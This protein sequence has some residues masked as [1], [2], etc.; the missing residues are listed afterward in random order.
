[1]IYYL[2]HTIITFALAYLFTI[3]PK[4]AGV[5][6]FQVK[7]LNIFQIITILNIILA[8]YLVASKTGIA[9]FNLLILIHLLADSFPLSSE[10]K[11]IVQ[12]AKIFNIISHILVGIFILVINPNLFGLF[13]I[14]II[15]ISI[16]A[17]D[18]NIEKDLFIK[19]K[20]GK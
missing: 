12:E 19:K 4:S 15:I 18:I 17:I 1:M 11:N 14:F 3:N 8:I 6:F 7:K 2:T 20:G 10:R 16:R 5:A 9:I 13:F